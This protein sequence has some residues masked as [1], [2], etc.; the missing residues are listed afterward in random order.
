MATWAWWPGIVVL[1]LNALVVWN[2]KASRSGAEGRGGG[3]WC[4]GRGR[5]GLG[6]VRV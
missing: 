1:G 4:A 6:C 3:G 5:R 2:S